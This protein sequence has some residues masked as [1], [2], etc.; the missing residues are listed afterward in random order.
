VSAF[1]ETDGLPGG[2]GPNPPCT[3]GQGQVDGTFATFSNFGPAIDLA[4]PG[5]SELGASPT[6]N[7]VYAWGTGTSFATHYLSGAAA[8]YRATHPTAT[9]SEVRAAL[10]A[11]AKP[12]GLP[13]DPDGIP[14]PIVDVSKF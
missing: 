9:P 6:G 10:I 3:A 12:G 8:L 5:V 13:G 11:A 7:G 1:T 14:E 2:G 4:A